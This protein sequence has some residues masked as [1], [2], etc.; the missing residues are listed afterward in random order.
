MPAGPCY[1]AEVTSELFHFSF[2]AYRLPFKQPVRT[3]HGLWTER[4]GVIVRLEAQSG[5]IGWGEAAPVAHFGMERQS[6]LAARCAAVPRLLERHVP[7]EW[8]VR[9]PTL[10]NAI[11]MALNEIGGPSPEVPTGAA[12]AAREPDGSSFYPV[13]A[14]LPA[15]RAALAA[16]PAKAEMGFRT[17]KWKV[18]VWDLGDELAILDDLC[19]ALPTGAVLRLDANGGWERRAAERWLEVCAKRPVEFVEQPVAADS[20][21]V[22]LL[23]GLS[24]DYP[25]PLALDES[26]VADQDLDQWIGRGWPGYYVVKPLLFADPIGALLKLEKAGAR[27]VFSSALETAVG[28]RAALRTAFRWK[29]ERRALG[30]GVWPLFGQ[31]TFD[32]PHAAPFLR[33][34]DVQAIDPEA[35]WSALS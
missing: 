28:A 11:E 4:E 26:L 29:G 9:C 35:V 34:S 6:D 31:P 17:F 21:A 10:A 8:A 20:G 25:T 16:V 15:G 1:N 18:G 19:A 33:R 27:V 14:F 2:R 12:V 30:F 3:S 24:G 23:L 22:D 7:A 5:K 32:G 13:A